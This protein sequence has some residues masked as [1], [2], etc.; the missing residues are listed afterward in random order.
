MNHVG[1]GR[2]DPSREL[3]P[4]EDTYIGYFYTLEFAAPHTDR[5]AFN[6]K[7]RE[8]MVLYKSQAEKE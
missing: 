7:K 1:L 5:V 4:T 6:V 3:P 8:D 2:N